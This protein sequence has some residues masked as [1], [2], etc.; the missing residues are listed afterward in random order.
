MDR[1]R[2]G[3]NFRKQPYWKLVLAIPLIYTPLLVTLPFVVLGV[4]LVWLHLKLIG[5]TQI[6]SYWDF[7]PSWISHRYRYENQITFGKSASRLSIARSRVY[8]LFNCKL[9]CPMSV[10][11]FAYANYLVKIVENW[12]CPFAHS[13]KQSYDGSA[14]DQSFWHTYPDE[15]KKLHS[16]DQKNPIWNDDIPNN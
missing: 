2:I 5:G 3:R 16:E 12:W 11:L 7:V 15:L 14:I 9:Y 8:W 4:F 1:V 10:A 6:K 13:K